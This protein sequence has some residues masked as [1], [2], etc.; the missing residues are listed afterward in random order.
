ARRD[1]GRHP[2]ATRQ[3]PKEVGDHLPA[4]GQPG[5]HGSSGRKTRY[6]RP[7]ARQHRRLSLAA[8]RVRH[9]ADAE[10]TQ[11]IRAYRMAGRACEARAVP[12]RT[13]DILAANRDNRS[14]ERFAIS[15]PV[16]GDAMS[17][18]DPRLD[19]DDEVSQAP[20]VPNRFVKWTAMALIA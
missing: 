12:H 14:V 18:H 3:R 6:G 9:S 4:E 5:P 19:Y 11:R 2:G 16:E 20:G 1:P 10:Q 17:G 7:S 15:G 13:V 8:N